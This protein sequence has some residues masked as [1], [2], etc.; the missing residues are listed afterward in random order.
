MSAAAEVLLVLDGVKMGS[1]VELNG[2]ALGNTTNQHLR[3]T[4]E[5]SA[6]LEKSGSNTLEV[7]FL[8]DIANS[9][10][11]MA[12][13]GGWVSTSHLPLLVIPGCILTD[14]LH[15]SAGLGAILSHAGHRRQSVLHARHLEVRLSCCHRAEGRRNRVNDVSLQATCHCV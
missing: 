6:L 15:A 7:S 4:F 3:Y 12:C 8:R 10:R 1:A 2:H 9:G 5:V 13:S 14:C 11:F